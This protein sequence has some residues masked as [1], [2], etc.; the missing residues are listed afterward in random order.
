M[1]T[2]DGT[3]DA[4]ARRPQSRQLAPDA[5]ARPSIHEKTRYVPHVPSEEFVVPLLRREIE[6]AIARYATPAIGNRK[7]LDM[8]CG[9]QP[10]RETLANAGYAYCSADVNPR[11]VEVDFECAADEPLP[12]GLLQRGPF[13]FVLCTEVLEHVADWGTAFANFAA[14]LAPGGRVLI[15]APFFYMLHEEPYDFWRPTLHA[16]E[17]YASRAGL[18]V[19]YRNAAGGP[20]EVLGTLLGTCSF[21]P[22]KRR[23]WDRAVAKAVRVSA[24][25]VRRAMT[26][27]IGIPFVRVEGPVYLSNIA[28]LEKGT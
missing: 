17:H 23:L 10:F 1:P 20:R 15:T 26:K 16:V 19:I 11:G 12:E 9:A 27:R 5:P 22:A 18:Q 4:A 25:L 6:G 24:G 8:G 3:G 2:V 14:L 7:A 13:D 28:V 21:L